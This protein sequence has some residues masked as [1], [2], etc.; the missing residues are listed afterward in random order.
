MENIRL[1]PSS[2]DSLYNSTM[3]LRFLFRDLLAKDQKKFLDLRESPDLGVYVQNLSSFVCKGVQEIEHVMNVGNKNRSVGY[4]RLEM[5][6]IMI[7]SMRLLR[8][9]DCAYFQC[10]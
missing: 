9:N 8:L 4:A 6:E 7:L 3:Y 10:D 5:E 2:L 1:V